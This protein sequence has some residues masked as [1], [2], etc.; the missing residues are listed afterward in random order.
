MSSDNTFLDSLDTPNST[1]WSAVFSLAFSVV[2]F[3]AAEL[4][5][6]SMLTP[7][8]SDLGVSEGLAGQAVSATSVTA[9]LCS[10]LMAIAT[11]KLDRR[12]VM[13]GFTVLFIAS[14]S[15]VALAT[16]FPMLLAGRVMLGIGLGGFWSMSSAVTLRLVPTDQVPRALSILFGGVSASMVI[17]APFGTFIGEVIG[18]RGV[19]FA[20]AVFGAIA[21]L[22]QYIDLPTMPPTSQPQL[23]T[24]LGLLKRPAIATGVV[25]MMLVFGGHFTFYTYLR[26]FLEGVTGISASVIS[27]LLFAFG[28]ANLV[29]T[30]LASSTIR[31]NLTLTLGLVPLAMAL[32]AIGLVW[33]G[34]I[35]L[36]AAILVSAW[37]FAFGAVPVAWTTWVTRTVPDEVESAG[38]LQVAAIQLS[39]SIGAAIGGILMDKTGAS[40]AFFGSAAILLAAAAL[41]LTRMPTQLRA[42]Q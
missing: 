2:G 13:L 39:I 6:I 11:R 24:L 17:A 29:G 28:I 5:P 1:R 10:L 8:A 34:H 27:S 38:G 30:S 18:W 16:N 12:T 26:P 32:L 15:V 14:N 23:A 33:Y 4:F 35:V 31:K 41:I 37:G 42:P 36:V 25:G 7:V 9:M 22:W 19:F 40:G 21:L 3:I 20:T